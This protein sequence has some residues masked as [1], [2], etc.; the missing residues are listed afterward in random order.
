MSRNRRPAGVALAML[1]CLAAAGCDE[2]S[3][4]VGPPSAA[5]TPAPGPTALHFH[6]GDKIK[7]V[8]IGEDKITGD[9]EVDS[10]G[11]IS[12]P[13]AG[14]LRASGLGKREL[15]AAIARKLRE[16]Q[17]LLNPMVTADIAAFRPFYVLGEVEKPGEYPYH[18]GL[19]ILSAVAV[20]GGDTYRANGSRALIQ[21]AGEA[22]FREYPLSPEVPVY[23]GDLI[24]VPERYF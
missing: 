10:S 21:R 6:V 1:A 23:P 14:T 13:I 5:K 22:N 8:V 15:E 19:N 17:Y 12:V 18:S 16:G 7:L 20:A 11:D 24:K 2:V 9:Y 3:S 4:L